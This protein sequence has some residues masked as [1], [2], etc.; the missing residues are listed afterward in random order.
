MTD[1]QVEL[2]PE[3][4]QEL[5]E[6]FD[7]Y[8]DRSSKAARSFLQEIHQALKAIEKAPRAW[9]QFEAN[10]RRYLLRRFP[11]YLVYR[12]SQNRILVLAIAHERRRP[13]YWHERR[14]EQ[15]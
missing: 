11:Y 12:P 5:T 4:S 13:G 9:P 15:Q 10:T 3:A 8:A 14:T 6:A 1:R 7:W 2:L